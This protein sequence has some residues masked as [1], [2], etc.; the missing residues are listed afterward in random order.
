MR[1]FKILAAAALTTLGSFVANAE[2]NKPTTYEF[3]VEGVHVI[4]RESY[5]GMQYQ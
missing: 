3:Q 1:K 4:L 2:D 5:N